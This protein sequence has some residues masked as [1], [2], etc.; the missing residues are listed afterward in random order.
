M[1]VYKR[2]SEKDTRYLIQNM[3]NLSDIDVNHKL[4]EKQFT[5]PQLDQLSEQQLFLNI[6]STIYVQSSVSPQDN[7]ATQVYGFIESHYDQPFS[8]DEISRQF[9]YSKPYIIN[10]IKQAYGQTPQQIHRQIRLEKAERMLIET[11]LSIDLI[12]EKLGY[13][14]SSYFIKQFKLYYHKTPLAYR[15]HS[16]NAIV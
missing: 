16:D 5:T 2:L 10:S 9:M 8:L 15:N 12:S 1:P 6:I 4:R 7:L 13:T 3:N 11:V 14:S